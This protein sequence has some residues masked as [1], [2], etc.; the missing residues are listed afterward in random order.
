MASQVGILHR[1]SVTRFPKLD[2]GL[3]TA[4][5]DKAHLGVGLHQ[6]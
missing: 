3:V 5:V 2:S 6:G 4:F 1:S